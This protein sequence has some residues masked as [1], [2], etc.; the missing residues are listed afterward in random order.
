ME[1]SAGRSWVYDFPFPTQV[2]LGA[3]REAEVERINN[4]I[5]QA[6]METCLA[7]TIFRCAHALA[8]ALPLLHAG[9]VLLESAALPQEL[10]HLPACLPHQ[11]SASPR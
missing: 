8:P 3:L 10:A 7:M 9:W 6:I 5:S 4:R 11:Q 2:F 1:P